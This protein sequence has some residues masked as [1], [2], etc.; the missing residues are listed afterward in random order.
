VGRKVRKNLNID[1][2]M[3]KRARRSLGLDTE[4][5]MIDR[6]LDDG[7]FERQLAELHRVFAPHLK[8]FRSPLVRRRPR[9]KR[10]S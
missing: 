6:L 4:T 3:L 5:E 1:P 8:D 9:S 2:E 10:S 7:E